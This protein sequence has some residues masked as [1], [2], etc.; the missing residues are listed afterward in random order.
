MYTFITYFDDNEILQGYFLISNDDSFVPKMFRNEKIFGEKLSNYT[1]ELFGG[2]LAVISSSYGMRRDTSDHFMKY[3]THHLATNGCLIGIGVSS[4]GFGENDFVSLAG[5]E[6]GFIVGFPIDYDEY[7]ERFSLINECNINA[8]AMFNFDD[9]DLPIDI[10]E[11][12]KEETWIMLG[13]TQK[14]YDMLVE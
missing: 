14:D 1:D 7:E 11:L 9:Y 10:V 3:Y 6:D 12:I 4:L 8:F 13:I 5:D 2:Y